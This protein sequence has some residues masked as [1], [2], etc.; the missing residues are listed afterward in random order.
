MTGRK[1]ENNSVHFRSDRIENFNGGW[2]FNIREQAQPFGPYSTRLD[3]EQAIKVYIRDLLRGVSPKKAF[4]NQ[5]ISDNF[6]RS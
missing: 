4:C 6:W 1:G 2:Y 3:A 5:L